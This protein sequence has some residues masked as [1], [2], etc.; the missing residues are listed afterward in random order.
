MVNKMAGVYDGKEL[1]REAVRENATDTWNL[2]SRYCNE[3]RY[4][5][6]TVEKTTHGV[7]K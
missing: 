6:G 3:I 1:R 2:P 7:K 4:P 5:D